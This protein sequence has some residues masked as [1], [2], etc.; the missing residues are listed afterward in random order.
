[1]HAGARE[2]PAHHSGLDRLPARVLLSHRTVC[3]LADPV[4]PDVTGIDDASP[5]VGAA[6]VTVAGLSP[7]SVDGSRSLSAR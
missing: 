1:M 6:S 5:I 3:V 7:I 2:R 4:S